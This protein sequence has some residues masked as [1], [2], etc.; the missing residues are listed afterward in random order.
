MSLIELMHY[1][2][3]LDQCINVY[4][5]VI[6]LKVRDRHSSCIS[7]CK[8]KQRDRSLSTQFN[9]IWYPQQ[10]TTSWANIQN[11]SN[12]RLKRPCNPR[13]RERIWYLIQ[14]M[15]GHKFSKPWL[16]LN[17]EISILLPMLKKYTQRIL[18]NLS[19]QTSGN[20]SNIIWP[21]LITYYDPDS[22]HHYWTLI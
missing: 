7:H 5:T 9:A 17:I 4:W 10:Y 2:M 21:I 15:C 14:R 16:L 11:I 6:L 18:H 8:S 19:M 12:R 22:M 20:T 3:F 13:V 1:V